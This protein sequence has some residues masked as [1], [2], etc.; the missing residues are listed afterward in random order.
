MW[1]VPLTA[2]MGNTVSVLLANVNTDAVVTDSSK[3]LAS[4]LNSNHLWTNCFLHQVLHPIVLS[5][6]IL[7]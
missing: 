2:F 7:N 6:D 5:S 3:M 1:D 4:Y